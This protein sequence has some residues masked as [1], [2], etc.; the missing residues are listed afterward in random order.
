M[1]H[2]GHVG[3]EIRVSG[4]Q[5]E[6][7]PESKLSKVPIGDDP[8]K[9]YEA[10]VAFFRA[11]PDVD[12]AFNTSSLATPWVLR[13]CK[14]IGISDKVIQIGTDDAPTN[15]E[16][17]LNGDITFTNGIQ[18]YL[19]GWF[20]PEVLYLYNERGLIADRYLQQS[21]VIIDETNVNEAKEMVINTIGQKAYD[22]MNPFK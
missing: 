16:G 5:Q 13:A 22:D 3:Q 14:E 21:I 2:V 15:L 17:I 8:A 1:A 20:P 9:G 10:L 7:P 11:N 19:N 18:F 4:F 12:V 6:L